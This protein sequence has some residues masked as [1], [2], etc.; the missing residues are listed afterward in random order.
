MF[1]LKLI[2]HL[3]FYLERQLA[4]G[5]FYQLLVAWMLVVLVSVT[6]GVL[7]TALHG[8]QEVYAENIWW[9]FLRLT[10]PGYLG[11]D[12]GVMRRVISTIL[13]VL[14]YVLFMG[15]LVAIMTQWL[16]AK[17]RTLEQG[18]TPV[19]LRRHIAVLGWTSR[20]IP[21]LL[22]VLGRGAL[23]DER[24]KRTQTRITVLAEDITEGAT[25]QFYSNAELSRQRRQVILRSGSMLNPEHLHRV[26]AANARVVII[27]SPAVT[28]AELLSADAEAIK[29]LL[30]LSAQ[31]PPEQLPLAIVELQSAEK[32]ALARHSY[33]GP[34]QLVAS[35]IA[36]ARAFSQSVLQPGV[37]DILDN[38]LV[39]AY[40]CQF[41]TSPAAALQGQPWRT[42]SQ[43]YKAAIPC[44]LIRRE[45][46]RSFPVLA[47]ADDLVIGRDDSLVLLAKAE[48]DIVMLPPDEAQE[49][50]LPAPDWSDYPPAKAQRSV[51]LLGW[52][53]RV[54]RFV[55]HIAQATSEQLSLT[56][57][58]TMPATERAQQLESLVL[59]CQLIEADYTR[60]SVLSKQSL[61]AYDSIVVFASDRLESGEEA[62]ARSIVA[63]QLLDLLLDDEQ[64]RPQ[65]VVE[66]TDPNNAVYVS[67][68]KY[69]LR[70]EVVQS[71]AIISHLL[72]QLAVYPELRAVYDTLL[73]PKG[74]GL[75]VRPVPHKWLG[76]HY[77][78]TL[79]QAVAAE[80]AVLLG[81]KHAKE[82][83]QLNLAPGFSVDCTEQTKLV[84]MG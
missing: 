40:G 53:G 29:V 2:D 73:S 69:K 26:A 14:G 68:N 38:L 23:L 43:H 9:A 45:E 57:I 17:M 13:T 12:Q 35:D 72:A 49:P 74:V 75:Q 52:N 31:R 78:R 67:A 61:S 46:G 28:P 32:I 65:V 27:P 5:A 37:S 51:L 55:E 15:T 81:V 34:L 60:P 10:D 70:S 58:S 8:P 22:D 71:S 54:P 56:S 21:I 3:K 50:R 4:K 64:Q 6:G 30:Y 39:D 19:S 63:N 77:F 79:Q 47:P 18:L 62:D 66:L 36:I 33:R 11:D 24:D 44:G 83:A 1:H 80:G 20:T 76:Q 48:R 7:V 59:D 16:S 82:R 41:Y 25:A 84:V 42:V